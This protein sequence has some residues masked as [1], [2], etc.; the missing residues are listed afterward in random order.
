MFPP[1]WLKKFRW[2]N[3]KRV[4]KADRLEWTRGVFQSLVGGKTKDYYFHL[5]GDSAVLGFRTE[6]GHISIYDVKV[7]TIWEGFEPK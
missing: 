4:T 6:K 3:A 5:S 2:D 1:K 7:R